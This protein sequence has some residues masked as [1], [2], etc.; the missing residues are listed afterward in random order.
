MKPSSK[1]RVVLRSPGAAASVTSA[2]ETLPSS[3]S[4]AC[5]PSGVAVDAASCSPPTTVTSCPKQYGG[6]IVRLSELRNSNAI[7]P[8]VM[9]LQ[10]R[11][12]A[13]GGNA[14]ASKRVPNISWSALG[15]SGAKEPS[16][17]SRAV[18]A[19]HAGCATFTD[20]VSHETTGSG[21]GGRVAKK[22]SR[23]AAAKRSKSTG[24][25]GRRAKR[26]GQSRL[27]K[28]FSLPVQTDGSLYAYRWSTVNGRRQ[29]HYNGQTF[30]GR[31]AH[32]LWSKIK[33]HT[34]TLECHKKA[35]K[36]S[37]VHSGTLA[38]EN[39]MLIV[40]KS[41]AGRSKQT[42]V[43]QPPISTPPRVLRRSDEARATKWSRMLLDDDDDDGVG[44]TPGP[45]AE[46]LVLTSDCGEEMG[47]GPQ[48]ESLTSWP[49]LRSENTGSLEEVDD[50]ST[51]SASGGSEECKGGHHNCAPSDEL[52]TEQRCCAPASL[53]EV[54]GK[55]RSAN[56]K[57]SIKNFLHFSSDATVGGPLEEANGCGAPAYHSMSIEPKS[58]VMTLVGCRG[59]SVVQP[60]VCR[61]CA[62]PTAS[63]STAYEQRYEEVDVIPDTL[64]TGAEGF[65]VVAEE[66]GAIRFAG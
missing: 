28:K 44:N 54:S 24:K 27:G 25:R 31:Q 63:L 14:E 48:S 60:N 21:K 30:C 41:T 59:R 42:P 62:L 43:E 5:G 19:A 61:P 56:V 47:S 22:R 4:A 58:K 12:A 11:T 52:A 45:P 40:R 55:S 36:S 17:C 35:V 65:F 57:I 39:G 66:A 32:M 18:P 3:A 34:P 33:A 6:A 13:I 7:L 26:G 49:S 9:S 29:L 46:V 38:V 50:L 37:S 10:C 53:V 2:A 15:V 8:G 1:F 20:A 23:K 51:A 64:G 16:A